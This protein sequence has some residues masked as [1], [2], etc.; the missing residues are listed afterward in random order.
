MTDLTS[1]EPSGLEPSNHEG[2]RGIRAGVDAQVDRGVSFVRKV[3]R[4][5]VGILAVW[6]LFCLVLLIAAIVGAHHLAQSI[7]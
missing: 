6:G 7:F 3:L 4:V 1:P 5:I 2:V